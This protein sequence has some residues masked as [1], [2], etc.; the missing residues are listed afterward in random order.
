LSIREPTGDLRISAVTRAVADATDAQVVKIVAK[1]D[2][3]AIRG[4]ADALIEPLRQRLRL[5]RPPRPLRFTRLMYDPLS[6]LIVPASRW[7]PGRCGLPR[8]MLP[9]MAEHVRLAMGPEGQAIDAEIAG[10]T[11]A[12]RDIIMRLGRSLWPTAAAIL[13]KPE[14]PDRWAASGLGEEMYRPLADTV[15]ALLAQAVPLDALCAETANGLLLPSPE[16]VGILLSQT[17]T[18]RADLPMLIVLLLTRLPGALGSIQRLSGPLAKVAA[19]ALDQ[20]I[21]RIL[22]QLTEDEGTEVLVAA[23][24]LADAGATASRIATFL[25]QLGAGVRKPQRHD[26]LRAL[27]R[28]LDETCRARFT[29]G[30]HEEL[31]APLQDLGAFPESSAINQVEAAA[32]G[33]RALELEARAVGSGATYDFLLRKA[34]GTIRDR[35]VR[36]GLTRV[37]QI[38]LVEI[39]SG[40]DEAQDMIT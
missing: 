22:I 10:H 34:A 25:E 23:G 31:L 6:P 37:D 2:A 40:P 35:A 12:D 3:I 38:R 21:D 33:L 11:S 27:R 13:A 16:R 28:H 20:A 26:Q 4:A 18:Q 29:L 39:L 32:R 19:A 17:T 8:T 24:T 36:D 1:I 7:L 30:L 5:L 14:M 15:A 9:P